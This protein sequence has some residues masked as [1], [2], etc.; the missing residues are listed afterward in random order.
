MADCKICAKQDDCPFAISSDIICS[1]YKQRSLTNADR[2]R[3]LSDEE[4]AEYLSKVQGDI[5]RGEMRLTHQWIDWL[6]SP[7][8]TEGE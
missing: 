2:I 6:K 7:A 4:L 1:S 8:K 5:F 3:A